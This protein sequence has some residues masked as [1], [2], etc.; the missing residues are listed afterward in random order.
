M[1]AS[2]GALLPA[3]QAGTCRAVA[4]LQSGLPSIQGLYFGKNQPMQMFQRRFKQCFL[5]PLSK[6]GAVQCWAVS[7]WPL[8]ESWGKILLP[9]S[10]QEPKK[11]PGDAITITASAP[12]PNEKRFYNVR[13]QASQARQN[14]LASMLSHRF[15]RAW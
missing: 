5:P 11:Y 8:P 14:P 10:C 1:M 15:R 3:V 9:G 2:A 13:L 7:V 12:A 4:Q 6:A